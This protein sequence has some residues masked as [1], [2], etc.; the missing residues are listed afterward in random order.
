MSVDA[1][2]IKSLCL[3]RWTVRTRAVKAILSNYEVLLKILIEV[4]NSGRDEH[5][6]K[7]G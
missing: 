3:R 1:P 2:T 5:A 4:Q 7:A 6:M